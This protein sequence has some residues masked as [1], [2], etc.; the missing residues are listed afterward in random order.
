MDEA[1]TRPAAT[2]RGLP[3]CA[4]CRYE[5]QWRAALNIARAIPG[6]SPSGLRAAP[7]PRREIRR[8]ADGT[9]PPHDPKR[10]CGGALHVEHFHKEGGTFSGRLARSLPRWRVSAHAKPLAF[11]TSRRSF[12][13]ASCSGVAFRTRHTDTR[14]MSSRFAISTGPMPSAA[15]ALISSAFAFA[16]GF[17]PSNGLRAWP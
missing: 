15:S 6:A 14:S 8:R 3:P 5:P 17:L 2:C 7:K 9:A 1:S 13:A 11:Q 12:A 4:S 10:A 16:V